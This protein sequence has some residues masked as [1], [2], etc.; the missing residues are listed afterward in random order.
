MKDKSIVRSKID[1]AVRFLHTKINGPI[2]FAIILGTGLEQ[3][4]RVVKIALKVE[5]DL[6]PDFPI[7]TA[8]THK[9]EMI[10]GEISGVRVILMNG[11]HHLY[12]G[13]SPSDVVLPIRVLAGLGVKNLIITNAAGALNED[14]APR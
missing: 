6:I 12:E 9:G 3:L 5:Y 7:S 13:W 10:I 2:N 1:N 8:P 14:L 4:T 11:R